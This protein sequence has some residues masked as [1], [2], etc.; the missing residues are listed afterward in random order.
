[1]TA[2]DER[3]AA[4]VGHVILK[5]ADL[6]RSTDYWEKIGMRII[7]T[8]D[9]V[10]VLELRGGTHLVLLKSD[11]PLP[12]GSAAAF[13]VMVEDVDAARKRYGELGFEP[14]EIEVGSIHRSFKLRDPSGYQVTV[15]SSHASDRPV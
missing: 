3:P 10:S 14:G 5:A 15:N 7:E 8:H 1:M 6:P 2:K 4:W 12:E 9:T 11:E 13:D